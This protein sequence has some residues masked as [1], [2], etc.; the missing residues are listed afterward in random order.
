[1]TMRTRFVAAFVYGAL[2][3]Q[4]CGGQKKAAIQGPLPK[5]EAMKPLLGRHEASARWE[6]AGPSA[7][8]LPADETLQVELTA[9]LTQARTLSTCQAAGLF[10]GTPIAASPG[11]CRDVRTTLGQLHLSSNLGTLDERFD[12]VN[13]LRRS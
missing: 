6:Y 13:D 2:F 7:C 3:G 1:M 12:E 8:T 9:D 5:P 4:G 10:E 11:N